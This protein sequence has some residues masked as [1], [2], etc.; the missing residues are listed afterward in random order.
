[1]T[2]THD[3][4]ET[5][6][7]EYNLLYRRNTPMETIHTSQDA[8]PMPAARRNTVIASSSQA[9]VETTAGKVR[10]YIR[11]GIFTF[12]G[13]PYGGS[14]GGAARFMP[15]TKPTPW[16][17]V[18]GCLHFGHVCPQGF[19]MVT[20]GDNTPVEDEDG[21]MIG[22]AYGQPAGEDCL[23]ANVWT[24]EINGSTK[25][26]VMVWMHGGGFSGGSGHDL[27]SYDGENLCHRGDVVVVTLNHRLNLFGHLNLAEIGGERYASSGNVGML[28]LVLAL[29]WVR[30]NIANFGGDPGNVMIFGQSGGG[31]KVTALMGMPS[32]KGLFHRAAVQSG[33]LLQMAQPADTSRLARAVLDEL[34]IRAE[35]LDKIHSVPVEHLVA[36]GQAALRKAVPP[37]NVTFDFATAAPR[38]GWAPTVDGVVLPS[39]P[40]DPV[41]PAMTANVPLLVGTDENE[42]VIGVD[43]PD[44]YSLTTEGLAKRVSERYGARSGDILNAF[45]RTYPKAQP[46]DLLSLIEAASVRQ[47]AV[48]QAERKAALGAAPA[49]L[50]LFTWHTPVLDGRPGAFHACEIPFVFDNVDRC[51]NYTG[52][53][54]EADVLSEQISQA[55]INFA[56]CGNPNHCALPEWPA[57]TPDLGQTMIFDAPCEV[58][59]N[60]DAEARR[61]IFEG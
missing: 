42:F 46:F 16:A 1:M 44:A 8:S 13:I 54:P 14:T 22:R 7:R 26:P 60:F 37:R 19:F 35:Q 18:R 39:H 56:R 47:A 11:N 36:A 4:D 3:V 58:R 33:S 61:S 51:H 21:F 38:L 49:Y 55:W 12:K 17:G 6:A 24:P 25:R 52:G 9:I 43:N 27:F 23:R 32:A 31:G 59:N 40:F 28:D 50:Y 48:T 29:E 45:R 10:G 5:P 34:G 2:Q 53:V 15:P 41:A 20:G 57:F 30:D